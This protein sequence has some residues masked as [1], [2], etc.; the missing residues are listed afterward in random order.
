MT[1]DTANLQQ[2]LEAVEGLRAEVNGLRQRLDD[3]EA[4]TSAVTEMSEEAQREELVAT[5]SAAIA[6]YLGF[7]PH[8]R[9][10]RLL[11]SAS[12][13]QHGRASIQ[14]SHQLSIQDQ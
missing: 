4:A 12:W 9:Q 8:I 2:I 10:I 5:I 14:A 7:K 3:I 6:A 1:T 13:A 11:G